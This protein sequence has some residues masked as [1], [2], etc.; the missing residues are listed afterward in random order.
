MSRVSDGGASAPEWSR[1]IMNRGQVMWAGGQE[2]ALGGNE[3]AVDGEA[4]GADV[5]QVVVSWGTS[6][7]MTVLGVR[8]V[9]AGES[10]SVGEE[11]DVLLPR[12]A[13]GAGRAEVLRYAGHTAVV[14]VPQGARVRVDGW[15]RTGE[16]REIEIV[17]GH[18]VEVYVGA[19]VIRMAL[20]RPALRFAAAPLESLR[21]SGVGSFAG[22]ALFHAAAFAFVAFLAPSLGAAEEDSYDRDRIA[23]MQHLLNA[24]A[25][26]ET[27]RVQDQ[28]TSASAGGSSGGR[29]AAGPGGAAATPTASN[30]AGHSPAHG[31]ARPDPV[32]L[33]RERMLADVSG[34]G[35]IGILKSMQPDLPASMDGWG[36]DLNRTQEVHVADVY[37]GGWDIGDA[38][39][40]GLDL[41]GGE[42]SGD[43]HGIGLT[44][45]GTLEGGCAS[46]V[47]GGDHVGVG[48]GRPGHGHVVRT[49]PV[50]YE[51]AQVN[52]R[53][54]P[55]LIQRVVR[56]NEGR[57]RSCFQ[58]GLRTNPNLA[59]RVAVKFVIDRHGQVALTTDGGSDLSD[60]SVRQCVISSFMSLSFPENDG[61]A[62]TVSYP[63]VFSPE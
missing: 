28:G 1:A 41:T 13:L 24:S 63:L 8:E 30:R 54:P 7:D 29:Q 43:P 31:D 10:L 39:G 23:L 45:F 42:G 3:N 22:S 27:E 47:G 25:E 49:P 36:R 50:R 46:C 35:V 60:A 56:Q 55:E 17:R 38:I 53:L 15:D 32:T 4:A 16:E 48:I 33:P 5:V 58:N 57:Y 2:A 21:D 37:G 11:G 26:R 62:V 19:F 34:F 20:V 12:E 14:L 51:I 59:G 18:T 52:G 44:G 6:P 61:G 9:K 40:T